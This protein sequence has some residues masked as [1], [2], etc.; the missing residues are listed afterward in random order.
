MPQ[1][2]YDYESNGWSLFL[3]KGLNGPGEFYYSWMLGFACKTTNNIV[4]GEAEEFYEDE[5]IVEVF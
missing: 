1:I 4:V 2:V 5:N 3:K